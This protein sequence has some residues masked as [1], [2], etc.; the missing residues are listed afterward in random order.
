MFLVSRGPYFIAA[1]AHKQV[2]ARDIVGTWGHVLFDSSLLQAAFDVPS[3]CRPCAR[4]A[5]ASPGAVNA[6]SHSKLAG[7]K[8]KIHIVDGCNQS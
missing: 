2:L 3:V 8:P 4:G 1:C 5:E 7:S 6:K